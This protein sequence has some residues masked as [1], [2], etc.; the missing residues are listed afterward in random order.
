MRRKVNEK[1]GHRMKVISAEDDL[2]KPDVTRLGSMIWA[3]VDQD[4]ITRG[5]YR[6]GIMTVRERGEICTTIW[7]NS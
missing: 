2:N 6:S 4:T 3:T 1:K 5:W 7:E